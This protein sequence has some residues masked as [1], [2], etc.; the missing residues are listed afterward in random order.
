MNEDKPVNKHK[1]LVN[2]QK[3]VGEVEIEVSRN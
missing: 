1:R 3:L 2:E